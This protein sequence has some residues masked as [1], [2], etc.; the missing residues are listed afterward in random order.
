MATN[1]EKILP[2]AAANLRLAHTTHREK[3]LFIAKSKR[4]KNY[5]REHGVARA[6]LHRRIRHG[7]Q[8]KK[9]IKT[10]FTARGAKSA[11]E[12]LIYC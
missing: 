12:K 2:L 5:Y 8:T 11:E 1:K 4:L 3:N 7:G 9:N 10:F 6:T